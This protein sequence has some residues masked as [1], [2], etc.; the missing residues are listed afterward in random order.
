VGRFFFCLPSRPLI[1]SFRRGRF[2]RL[3]TAGTEAKIR[4]MGP[5]FFSF[6]LF[7]F[8]K[9]TSSETKKKTK[10][11]NLAGLPKIDFEFG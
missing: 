7:L 4:I 2:C 10:I 9:E 3:L 8:L 5:R 6:F 1:W 11:E